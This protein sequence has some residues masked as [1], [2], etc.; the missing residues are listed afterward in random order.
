MRKRPRS[1]LCDSIMKSS[2]AP[3]PGG[4]LSCLTVILNSL[5]PP[6]NQRCGPGGATS[7]LWVQSFIHK[8]RRPGWISTRSLA[9]FAPVLLC[10]DRAFWGQ[11]PSQGVQISPTN[12]L[13]VNLCPL[14][15]LDALIHPENVQIPER[16]RDGCLEREAS[17]SHT[18]QRGIGFLPILKPGRAL[19]LP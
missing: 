10:F 19:C 1:W 2:H 4:Q 18:R 14:V 15:S 7:P 3:S 17:L 13:R 5:P 8:R 6:A 16:W 11:V 9:A 12:Q